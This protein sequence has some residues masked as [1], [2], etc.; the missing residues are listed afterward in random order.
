MTH[1]ANTLRKSSGVISI[2]YEDSRGE[3]KLSP[4]EEKYLERLR[5]SGNGR[6]TKEQMYLEGVKRL[7]LD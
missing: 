1:Q 4:E 6:T 2:R 3:R 7:F 5:V